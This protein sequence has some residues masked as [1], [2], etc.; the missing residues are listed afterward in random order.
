MGVGVGI[1]VGLGVALAFAF[2]AKKCKKRSLTPRWS[3]RRLSLHFSWARSSDAS[4]TARVPLVGVVHA[5][6]R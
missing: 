3:Q 5:L 6:D 2:R 1:G 4:I